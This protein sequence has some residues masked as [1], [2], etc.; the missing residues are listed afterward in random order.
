MKLKHHARRLKQRL[1]RRARVY[2]SEE[3]LFAAVRLHLANARARRARRERRQR[4]TLSPA[5][6]AVLAGITT[7]GAFTLEAVLAMYSDVERVSLS[8]PVSR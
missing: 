7:S 3:E 1:S 6:T 4:V 8:L 2:G 5:E